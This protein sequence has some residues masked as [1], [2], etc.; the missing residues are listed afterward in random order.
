MKNK[1]RNFNK[2]NKV[3]IHINKFC[4]FAYEAISN[5]KGEEFLKDFTD[6]LH[7]RKQSTNSTAS[8]LA[9]DFIK[10]PRK[11]ETYMESEKAAFKNFKAFCIG[12]EKNS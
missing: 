9:F 8:K 11:K 1:N 5:G 6:T 2:I 10:N 7:N 4:M 12:M 3:K